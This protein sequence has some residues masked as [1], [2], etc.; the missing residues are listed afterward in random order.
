ML[1]LK[2]CDCQILSVYLTQTSKNLLFWKKID[3]AYGMTLGLICGWTWYQYNEDSKL[4]PQQARRRGVLG[5]RSNPLWNSIV[6]NEPP[7]KWMNSPL[8]SKRTPPPQKKK[9]PQLKSVLKIL[10]SKKKHPQFG[11]KIS[12]LKKTNTLWKT[13]ATRLHRVLLYT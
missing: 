12:F 10:F 2:L 3:I 13:S 11:K 5:V 9:R 4:D 8:W 6:V 7:L 1:L